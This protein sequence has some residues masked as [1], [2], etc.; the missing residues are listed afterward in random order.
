MLLS[1]F[2]RSNNAACSRPEAEREGLWFPVLSAIFELQAHTRSK[3]KSSRDE[4]LTLTH[5]MTRFEQHLN[6]TLVMQ[7]IQDT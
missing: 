3:L 1:A 4:F 5:D 2:Q 7:T 6:T